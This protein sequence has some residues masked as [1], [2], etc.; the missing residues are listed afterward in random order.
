MVLVVGRRQLRVVVR[1]KIRYGPGSACAVLSEVQRA[2][3]AAFVKILM[4]A[5][6]EISREEVSQQSTKRSKNIIDP[7]IKGSPNRGSFVFIAFTIWQM[8]LALCNH[9]YQQ[10]VVL[11]YILYEQNLLGLDLDSFPM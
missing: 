3:F 9:L 4:T 2:D 6:R 11:E 8:L 1:P 5:Q 7:K 10:A